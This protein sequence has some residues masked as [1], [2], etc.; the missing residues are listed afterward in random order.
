MKILRFPDPRLRI[1]AKD[2]KFVDSETKI[3]LEKMKEL[4]YAEDGIGLAA[5][6]VGIPLKIFVFDLSEE[7]NDPKVAINPKIIQFSREKIIFNE[8]CLSIP[9][10]RIPVERA[11]KISVEWFDENG[12]RFVQ[13]LEDLSAVLFQHE[14]DHL[15]GKLI[16]DKLP[17][18]ERREII[19][20]L[21]SGKLPEKLSTS[22]IPP[23]YTIA[24]KPK[25]KKKSNSDSSVT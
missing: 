9:N 1:K 25:E 19:K 6:Q 16:I 15:L 8:G 7:K 14:I 23:T 11:K 24:V 10:L 20:N 4:M 21:L 18:E 22:G 2:L 17:T 12:N 13:Q 3:I 5:T